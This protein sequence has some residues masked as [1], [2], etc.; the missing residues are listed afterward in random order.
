MVILKKKG[1]GFIPPKNYKN[2]KTYKPKTVFVSGKSSEEEKEQV[3]RKQTNKEFLA[4][5]QEEMKKGIAWKKKETRTCFQC[6]TVGHITRN[7]PMAIKSKQGV[8]EKLKKKVVEKNKLPTKRFKVFENST[9]EVGECSKS[10]CKRKEKLNNQKWVVKNS[11]DSSGDESDSTKSEEPQVVMK[12]EKSIP[13]LDD[14]NFP[15]LRV[16][17]LKSKIGKVEISNQFFPE[18]KEFDVEK[19]FNPTVK[20]IFDKMVDGKAKGV[21]EF[22]EIKRNVQIPGEIEKVTPKA[23]QAWVSV[24]FA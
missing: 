19:A 21:K 24:F 20:N 9:F 22:Y 6:K 18:K 4:K 16:E 11:S 12:K 10:V 3:F 23:G 13:P 14:A 17:N 7:C 15:P 5:K 8:S 2:E 1:L